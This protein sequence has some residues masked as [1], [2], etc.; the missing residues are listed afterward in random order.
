MSSRVTRLLVALAASAALIVAAA[1][2][3]GSHAPLSSNPHDAL[4]QVQDAI[5]S[6]SGYTLAVEQSNFVLPG[7]GGADGGTV[8]VGGHG[9]EAWATLARTGEQN[10]TYKIFDT[11]GITT[12]QR[13]TC[14]QA[15]QVS[16]RVDVLEPYIF[17]RA[18]AIANATNASVNG[19]TITANLAG[20][21]KVV[22]EVD[23]KTH[24]PMSIS[25]SNAS[26]PIVW[27]FK[28]WSAVK[29]TPPSSTAG[30]RGPGG[31]PC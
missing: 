1:A 28:N 21:G 7:W 24:R 4:A 11:G 19:S 31:I 17:A 2:C 25:A 9:A 30:E 20:L 15:Y 5:D 27:T 3:G 13:S 22:I 18:N 16:G 29:V 14:G 10:A 26:G 12:F 6:A 8:Y 23:P